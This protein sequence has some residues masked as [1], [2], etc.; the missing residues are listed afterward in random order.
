MS[1]KIPAPNLQDRHPNYI[2]LMWRNEATLRAYRV[3]AADSLNNAYGNFNGVAGV[4][5]RALFDVEQGTSFVSPT[6][7]R[8]GLGQVSG[9]NRV[10]TIAV[11]DP[12]DYYNPPASA[13]IFPEGQIGFI[14]TQVR[15]KMAGFPGAITNINQSAIKIVP[16]AYFISTI[17]WPSITLNGT[18]PALAGV[19][20]GAMPPDDAMQILTPPFTQNMI[21]R[22]EGIVPILYSTNPGMPLVTL[23]ASGEVTQMMGTVLSICSTGNPTFRLILEFR[24]VGD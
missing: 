18:A 20:P 8:K 21:L 4:G 24:V 13:P 16:P 1:L 7:Q 5:T 15:T 23:P 10:Q 12:S 9:S 17:F 3:L 14:R 19:V 6:I 11:Y 2:H 22:N